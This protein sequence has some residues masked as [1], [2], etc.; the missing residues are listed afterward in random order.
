MT[1]SANRISAYVMF[2]V[3]VVEFVVGAVLLTMSTVESLSSAGTT[4]MIVGGFLIL[5][6]VIMVLVGVRFLKKYAEGRR[7]QENGVAGTA[8]VLQARQTGVLVN[9][10]PQVALDL[11]VTCP[12]HGTYEVRRK[13]IVP[14]LLL[15]RVTSGQPLTVL[16]DPQD[17][18]KL[19]VDWSATPSMTPD[20][21]AALNAL[22][23]PATPPPAPAMDPADAERM[24][25]QILATGVPGVARVLSTEFTGALDQQGRPVYN[26]QFHVQIEGRPPFA[27]GAQVAV[28]L[29][30][31]SVMQPGG[32]IPIK[33]DPY[34]PSKFAADWNRLP[35]S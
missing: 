22:G 6:G 26:A 5:S 25:Q 19:L 31:V 14:M 32:E 23:I 18:E 35:A 16:V 3:A 17:R 30:R 9:N 10:Q 34:D 8:Q 27:G 15:S 29:E 13:E 12:G 28:P 24:K 21:L 4:L 2:F 1:L 20:P 33:A 11:R 7:L